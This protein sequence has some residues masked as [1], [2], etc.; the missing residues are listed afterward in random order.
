MCALLDG[1][2]MVNSAPLRGIY[3]HQRKVDKHGANSERVGGKEWTPFEIAQKRG[4]G[5]R[6]FHTGLRE[7]VG[8]PREGNRGEGALKVI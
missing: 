6:G 5:K 3:L 2:A 7:A 8:R 1:G 4:G